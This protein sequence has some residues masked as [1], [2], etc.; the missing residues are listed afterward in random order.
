MYPYLYRYLPYPPVDFP[1]LIHKPK[2]D[3]FTS[4]PHFVAPLRTRTRLPTCLTQVT[5]FGSAPT[6]NMETSPL[7]LD[8]M[9]A[10]GTTRPALTPTEREHALIGAVRLALVVDALDAAL[11][12]RTRARATPARGAA[13]RARA[14]PLVLA[15]EKP[16]AVAVHAV[17]HAQLVRALEE[18]REERGRDV[19]PHV[20][21]RDRL[22]AA[23]RRE[24]RLVARR[25]LEQARHA[26]LVEVVPA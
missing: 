17:R 24:E 16:P 11:A 9:L 22:R 14:Q 12:P 7:E 10:A 15:P 18:A 20:L 25:G 19:P 26:H 5:E 4:E 2:H 6:S 13:E 3:V 1:F 23:A 8:E 21:E